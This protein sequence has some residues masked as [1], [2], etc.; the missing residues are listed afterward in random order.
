MPLNYILISFLNIPFL[1]YLYPILLYLKVILN[2]LC[3]LYYASNVY[4]Y[5]HLGI[6]SNTIYS[7]MIYKCKL[8]KLNTIH[9]LIMCKIY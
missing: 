7:H 5:Y 9:D 6:K 3:D 8:S 2:S 4:E 1:S